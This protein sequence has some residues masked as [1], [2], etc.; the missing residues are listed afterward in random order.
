MSGKKVKKV[1]KKKII[2]NI[3]PIINKSMID[4]NAM[5]TIAS[6]GDNTTGYTSYI[7]E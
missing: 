1:V 3:N 7:R 2:S 6:G 5:A 4:P